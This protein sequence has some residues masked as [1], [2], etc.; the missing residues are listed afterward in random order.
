MLLVYFVV[1]ES[2]S[3]FITSVP[4]IILYSLSGINR[5]LCYLDE[6]RDSGAGCSSMWGC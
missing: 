6:G 1:C 2:I 3:I 4:V 5:V